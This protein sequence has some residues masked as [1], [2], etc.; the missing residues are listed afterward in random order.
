MMLLPVDISG[1]KRIATRI[2]CICSCVEPIGEECVA[3]A[4]GRKWSELII[5]N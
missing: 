3:Y 2:D 4:D 5:R 1:V